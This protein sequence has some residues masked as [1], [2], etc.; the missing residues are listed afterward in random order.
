MNQSV[1][2]FSSHH[3]LKCNSP[4]C[5][6]RRESS[7]FYIYKCQWLSVAVAI[8]GPIE[9]FPISLQE[10]ESYVINC[11]AASLLSTRSHPP[12]RPRSL[13]YR[14]R[15]SQQ[16]SFRG[17]LGCTYIFSFLDLAAGRPE[18]VLDGPHVTAS[19]YWLSRGCMR[20]RRI[21]GANGD[22]RP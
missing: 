3:C 14:R 7:I 19:R 4:Q 12:S 21:S 1:V 5:I 2:S 22:G 18:S 15:K 11:I 20:P 13:V 6:L 9:W 16:S 17:Y 10:W 8:V